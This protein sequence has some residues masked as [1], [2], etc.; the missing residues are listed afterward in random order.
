MLAT[1]E[2]HPAAPADSAIIWMH[3]L[4]A[5]SSDFLSVLPHLD[6][7]ST[8]F[9][10]PQAPTRPVTINAGYLMPAWYDIRTLE[11][12]PN[13]ED[14]AGIDASALAIDALIAR[15]RARGLASERIVLAGFS[16]GGAM[17]LH[18]AHRHAHTLAGIVVLSAYPLVVERWGEGHPANAETPAFCAHGI[19]DDVVS[20]DRGQQGAALLGDRAQ[21]RDYGMGHELCMEEI[22]DLRSWLQQR[23][24]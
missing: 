22:L 2:Q 10:F 4:G 12:G 17:A 16:Q 6:L 5:S 24:R 7:P 11:P 23:L 1:L 20:I 9:V 18:V 19:G 3:G 21:W 15:E 8:R 13:R 14:A